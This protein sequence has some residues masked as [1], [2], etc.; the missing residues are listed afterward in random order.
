MKIY[1]NP[2]SGMII[3]EGIGSF[4]PNTVVAAREDQKLSVWSEDQVTRIIG[5]IHYSRI[6]DIN[7]NEFL[8]ANSLKQYLDDVFSTDP[9][10]IDLA[11]IFQEGLL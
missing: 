2:T 6:T 5:P 8:T 4:H 1:S 9:T 11:A 10:A 7:N 3:I